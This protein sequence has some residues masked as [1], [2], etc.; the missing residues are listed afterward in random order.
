MANLI[1]VGEAG[2]Y[3][4]VLGWLDD[5]ILL[6]QSNAIGNPD[7]GSQLFTVG[8]DGSNLTKVADGSLVAV[9]DNR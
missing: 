3:Y 4:T 7:V 8:V 5:Q 9:I 1:L 6:V 2:S